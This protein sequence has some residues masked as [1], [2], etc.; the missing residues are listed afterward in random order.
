VAT[1]RSEA[2]KIGGRQTHPLWIPPR[3]GCTK[4]NVD[5]A[6][7]KETCDGAVGVVCRSEA[8]LFLGASSLKIR[9]IA[10]PS[11]LEAIACRK[12]IA[13]AQDLNLQWISV[14]TDCLAVVN[15]IARPCA[16]RYSIVIHEI[17]SP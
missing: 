10:D 6:T 9:G 17:R 13:L 1:T 7:T 16:E 15:D 12:A 3:E 2:T 14:A 4:V 11:T 8:G 5:A